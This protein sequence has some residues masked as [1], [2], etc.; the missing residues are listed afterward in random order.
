MINQH[1]QFSMFCVH[2]GVY[3]A[4]YP[5]RPQACL[6]GRVSQ[7]HNAKIPHLQ[8]QQSH[9]HHKALPAQQSKRKEHRQTQQ[10][11]QC[12]HSLATHKHLLL[13]RWLHHLKQQNQHQKHRHGDF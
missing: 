11:Q 8:E 2:N 6:L 13:V 3:C 4:W 7:Q 9:Q 12:F 1:T 10:V 5:C